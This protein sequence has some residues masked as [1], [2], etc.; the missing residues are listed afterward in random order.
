[1]QQC[2]RCQTSA[3]WACPNGWRSVSRKVSR[4]IGDH[5][6]S[7]VRGVMY[8]NGPFRDEPLNVFGSLGLSKFRLFNGFGHFRSNFPFTL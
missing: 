5:S 7:T 6:V 1:M 3:R 8:S 2:A 4:P